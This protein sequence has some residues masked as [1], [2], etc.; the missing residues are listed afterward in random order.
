M[1]GSEMRICGTG[2]GHLGIKEQDE[3][4]VTSVSYDLLPQH[5]LG[6]V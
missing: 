1:Q 5:R 6:D 3:A 2:T 4:A